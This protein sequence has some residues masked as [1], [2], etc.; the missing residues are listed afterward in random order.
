MGG[1]QEK[2]SGSIERVTFHNPENGFAVLRVGVKGK[3][4]TVVGGGRALPGATLDVY[5][6]QQTEGPFYPTALPADMDNDLVQVRG[7]IDPLRQRIRGEE[8]EVK[9]LRDLAA[10][11]IGDETV[12]AEP[13]S[14]VSGPRGMKPM[15]SSTS[16]RATSGVMTGV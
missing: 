1:M 6:P 8:R 13:G 12:H 7:Q 3:Q 11:Q 4:V 10:A 9:F 16:S 14:F 15:P 2:L 5:G